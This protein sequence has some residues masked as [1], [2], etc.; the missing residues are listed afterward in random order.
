MCE[1]VEANERRYRGSEVG[2]LVE[3]QLREAFPESGPFRRAGCDR[4]L[5]GKTGGLH[6]RYSW[7]KAAGRRG[8]S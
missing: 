5:S 3:Q 2:A 8:S 6:H 1:V 4:E 7:Q